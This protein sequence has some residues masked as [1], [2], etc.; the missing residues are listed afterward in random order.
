MPKNTKIVFWNFLEKI[1]SERDTTTL[2]RSWD[3]ER[4]AI[5]FQKARQWYL[6]HDRANL[7]LNR[8]WY[9]HA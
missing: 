2:K 5:S 7:T 4:K 9:L 8:N 6:L 1:T 3:A